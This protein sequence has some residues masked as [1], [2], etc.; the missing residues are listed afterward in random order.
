MEKAI[1]YPFTDLA[2]QQ[3]EG[4]LRIV[5]G[6]GVRVY[7]EDGRAYLEGTSGLWC[8]SL[9]FSENRLA[10][11]ADR[12]LRTLPYYQLF[13][14]R[15]HGVAERLAERLLELVPAP[16]SAVF[17][18]NSGSEANDTAV[19]LVWYY[20]NARGRPEKK[21]I[22]AHRLGYHGSTIATASLTGLSLNHTDFDLPLPWVRHV[23]CPHHYHN[24]RPG[25]GEE[26]FARRL[27]GEL[28]ALIEAEGPETVAAFIT[29]PVLGGGGVIVPP[30]GYFEEVQRVLHKHDVLLVADEVICGFGRTG[31]MFGCGRFGLRP[32]VMTFAKALSSSYLPISATV[33]SDEIA[34]AIVPHTALRGGLGHGFT[35]GGHPVCCAVALETL[36]IYAERDIVGHVR[37]V[38]PVLQDRLRRFADHPLVGE[39]RGVGLIAAVELVEDGA[40]ERLVRHAM[41]RGALLRPLGDTISFC[42]PL[43]STAGELTELVGIFGD[44]L[45]D[46]SR[47]LPNAVHPSAARA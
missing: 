42:P 47:E 21:K 40:G 23:T 8:V 39:V 17:F 45:E 25:E 33:V 28:D 14:Q 24:A 16:L 37:E 5:R 10:G 26:E 30:R 4:S 11:A 19:K 27:A 38:A 2:R 6:D 36:D 46:L 3:R 12:Q 35:T 13:N 41:R 20:N 1:L 34:E 44:A 32:D 31:A 18:G 15:T 43:I 22:I 9:G 7:D 29:E